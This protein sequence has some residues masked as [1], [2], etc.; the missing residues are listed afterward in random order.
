LLALCSGAAA[1]DRSALNDVDEK[2]FKQLVKIADNA[3]EAILQV[4]SRSDLSVSKK[5]DSEGVVSPVT[6]AD[7]ESHDVLVAGL[8]E[9]TSPLAAL[10]IVSEEDG[11]EPDGTSLMSHTFYWVLDPLDGTKEFIKG[12]PDYTVNIAL[13]S[14]ADGIPVLGVVQAPPT[15]ECW[16]GALR[17]NENAQVYDTAPV[18]YRQKHGVPF[19][20]VPMRSAL[21]SPPDG[22]WRVAV[23]RSHGG[24]GVDAAARH[25]IKSRLS[26]PA[27]T[28]V[29]TASLVL[30][31]AGS[32]LKLM[33]VGTGVVDVYP[34]TGPTMFWDTAAAHALVM[35]LGCDVYELHDNHPTTSL[36]YFPKQRTKNPPFVVLPPKQHGRHSDEL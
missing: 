18:H 36:R 4:R 35:A 34:R 33:W 24:G 27:S 19:D 10:P 22:G 31:E 28:E 7:K 29:D 6:A 5:A 8:K 30:R 20:V 12:H 9:L 32:S 16:Y 2:L 15:G 25:A 13:V 11:V 14:A 21:S 23:S 1:V 26:P 17:W 3:G